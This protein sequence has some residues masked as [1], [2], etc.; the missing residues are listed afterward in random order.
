MRYLKNVGRTNAAR[1]GQAMSGF[2]RRQMIR[3][4]LLGTATVSLRRLAEAQQPVPEVTRAGTPDSAIIL[5]GGVA[6]EH[7]G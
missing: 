7:L 1:K 4:A 6:V 3:G 2:S 5:P